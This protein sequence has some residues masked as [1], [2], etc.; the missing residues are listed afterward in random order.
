MEDTP[1]LLGWRNLTGRWDVSFRE[2]YTVIVFQFESIY[3]MDLASNF[4]GIIFMLQPAVVGYA[5][6]QENFKTFVTWA[7]PASEILTKAGTPPVSNE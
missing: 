7:E 4:T 1:F 2:G 6:C 5:D 3:H